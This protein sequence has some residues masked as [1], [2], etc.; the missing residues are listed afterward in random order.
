M[1]ILR[2]FEQCVPEFSYVCTYDQER[3]LICRPSTFQPSIYPYIHSPT[4]Q[5]IRPSSSSCRYTLIVRKKLKSLPD[6][7]MITPGSCGCQWSSLISSC[8]WWMKNSWAG[9]PG[10]SSLRSAFVASTSHNVSSLS[11]LE[12]A[13][14]ERSW[15]H[16]SIE[17]IG[18]EWYLNLATVRNEVTAWPGWKQITKIVPS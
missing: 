5:F 13:R 15:G 3:Y 18:P 2:N 9:T 12:A 6:V 4:H 16:H 10:M 11:S 14:T 8:P 1:T 17:V 7:L